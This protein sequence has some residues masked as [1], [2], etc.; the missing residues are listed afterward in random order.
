MTDIHIVDIP[1]V[2]SKFKQKRVG[3]PVERYNPTPVT[4]TPIVIDPRPPHVQLGHTLRDAAKRRKRKGWRRVE[5]GGMP[6]G[7]K[8]KRMTDREWEQFGRDL[9]LLACFQHD[10]GSA[11]ERHRKTKQ[12]KRGP[13]D[14][15]TKDYLQTMAWGLGKNAWRKHLKS[16]QR[17]SISPTPTTSRTVATIINDATVARRILTPKH[18][19][20]KW[21]RA[22][23]IDVQSVDAEWEKLG[24][25]QDHFKFLSR[26][27]IAKQPNIAGMIVHALR[28]NPSQSWDRLSAAIGGWCSDSTIRRWLTS[29]DGYEKYSERFLPLLTGIQKEKHLAFARHLRENWGKGKGKFLLIHFDE[30]WFWGLVA[31]RTAKAVPELDL[32]KTDLHVYH[33]SH[34]EKVMGTAVT[35]YAFEDCM[36][37]GG[38]G[39]KLGFYRAQCTKRAKKLV[40]KY[41]SKTGKYD[42]DVVRKKGDL[43]TVD[44]TITGT[45]QGSMSYPKWPLKRMF[46]KSI[47]PML[48]ELTQGR[49]AKFKGYTVVIQGDNAGPHVP[50][51]KW[52]ETICKTEEWLLE[53]Q[54]PQGPHFNN[55]DL[56][57][58]PAMSK[59]HTALCRQ[60]AGLRVASRDEIWDAAKK[61]WDEYPSAMIARGFVNVYR[62]CGRVIEEK[63]CN[64]FLG[65][66]GDRHLGITQDFED[67]D[68][69]IRRRK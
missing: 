64:K 24:K 33:K 66:E 60:M 5:L 48:K 47:I 44:T 45:D 56:S 1:Q 30:K 29:F 51:H 40:R 63:G 11:Q 52:L 25:K 2:S 36:D 3:K 31:R 68:D 15:A 58:F 13:L 57:V 28:T 53:P 39:I 32:A 27:A 23:E 34:I 20:L 69:G 61:V 65:R 50:L 10:H 46:E 16:R 17:Q 35:G 38:I 67:M 14:G 37:N 26:G 55:L 8:K 18:F 21:A 49:R 42:G 12:F 41:N 62:I 43:Y 59:R 7:K 9:E 4:V 22:N 6:P 54:A 19:F